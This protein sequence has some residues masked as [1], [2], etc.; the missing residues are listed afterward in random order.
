MMG[1]RN[2]FYCVS[3]FI[4]AAGGWICP[5]YGVP[6]YICGGDFNLRI[7]QEPDS[8]YGWMADAVIDIPVHYNISDLDVKI[9]ITHSS[10]FDLRLFLVNPAG[11]SVVLNE[12]LDLNDFFYSPNYTQTIFD[13][14]ALVSV[15]DGE[16]PFTGRYRPRE[17][18]NIFDGEDTFGAWRLLIYDQCLNDSG[19]LDSFEMFISVPEPAAIFLLGFGSLFML[20]R[21][22][23]RR[24]K[25]H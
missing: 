4:V 6:V 5:I 10:A 20:L 11:I 19:Y 15:E 16:A 13:D 2:I 14:E 9:S 17:S 7:P 18:L 24:F 1:A 8:S 25:K 22:S 3:V 12:Y 23:N 21:N